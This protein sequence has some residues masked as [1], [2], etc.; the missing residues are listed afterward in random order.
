M[1]HGPQ[2]ARW[3]GQAGCSWF[4][5]LREHGTGAGASGGVG[6]ATTSL[7]APVEVVKSAT[8]CASA[9][10]NDANLRGA[11]HHLR[12]MRGTSLFELLVVLALAGIASG[13]ATVGIGRLRDRLAVEAETAKVLTT[14][15]RARLAALTANRPVALQLSGARLAAYLLI[16]PD[17]TLVWSETGPTSAGVTIA[18][19]SRVVFAPSGITLGVANGRYVL[20][21]GGIRRT[22]V[23]SRLG[24]LRVTRPRRVRPTRPRAGSAG[25][26][27]SGSSGQCPGGGRRGACCHQ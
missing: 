12:R 14:Y 17:S 7:N 9:R 19:P 18:G 16:G 3:D 5:E 8:S 20:D 23:A 22:V 27:G 25:P 10:E 6:N 2:R 24:R 1:S 11:A 26:S 13:V 4:L 15:Q 21:R